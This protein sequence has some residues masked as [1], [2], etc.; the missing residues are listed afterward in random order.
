MY[1]YGQKMVGWT[2]EMQEHA[3]VLG[4][5]KGDYTEYFA[6]KLRQDA[7]AMRGKIDKERGEKALE[8][9]LNELNALSPETE[10]ALLKSQQE[11]AKRQEW[12]GIRLLRFAPEN[13][14][15]A[16]AAQLL[17]RS[18]SEGIYF[19][20]CNKVSAALPA[21]RKWSF[22]C[23]HC[24]HDHMLGVELKR[25][26]QKALEIMEVKPDGAKKSV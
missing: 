11:L 20:S 1:M 9:A 23:P 26:E 10:E 22:I 4:L 2:D 15:K 19:C 17:L 25:Q 14:E 21:W 18:L 24:K 13:T 16:K 8:T 7:D 3:L 6:R 12:A 5:Q